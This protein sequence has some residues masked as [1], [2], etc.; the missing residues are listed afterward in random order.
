M[1]GLVFILNFLMLIA[2]LVMFAVAF[3]SALDTVQIGGWRLLFSGPI[4][5]FQ[6]PPGLDP[7]VW[8]RRRRS[9]M[10][11]YGGSLA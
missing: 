1:S 8:R 9:A 5:W 7:A 6:P 3:V 10:C 2:T 4:G 11:F